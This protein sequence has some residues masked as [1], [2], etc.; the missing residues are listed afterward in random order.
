LPHAFVQA[1]KCVCVF[2]ENEAHSVLSPTG[3]SRR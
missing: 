1:C 3:R 2:D